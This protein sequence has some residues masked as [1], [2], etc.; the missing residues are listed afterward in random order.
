MKINGQGKRLRIAVDGYV[1]LF[2]Q[3]NDLFVMLD[4]VGVT[5]VAY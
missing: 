1:T 2:E 5:L 3:A 4:A